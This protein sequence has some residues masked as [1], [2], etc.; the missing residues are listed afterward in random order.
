MC[1]TICMERTATGV[2]ATRNAVY[3]TAY[4]AVWIPKYRKAVLEGEIAD[5]L[6]G[7]IGEIAGQKGFEVLALEIQP[8]HVRVFF[9]PPPAIAPA[10][11]IQWFKGISAKKLFADFPALR[12][13]L[14]GG[15]L[16]SPSFYVGTAGSV[17][18]ETIKRYI[19]RAEHIGSRR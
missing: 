3:Q 5:R 8:D 7:I 13:Q 6:R 18:A 14:W 19:E 16:W 12:Q 17:S 11:A 4:H 15:H 1:D 9:S 2:R 10:L